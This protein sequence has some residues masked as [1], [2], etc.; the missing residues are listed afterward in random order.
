MAETFAT[1]MTVYAT[2]I[3]N[4]PDVIERI[5]GPDGDEWRKQFYPTIET[6]EN[7]MEHLVFNAV[8][9]GVHDIARLDGWA[10]CDSDAV[11]VEIDDTA[12]STW[13]PTS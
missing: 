1:E 8:V 12:F 13:K 10:D 4:D 6:A 3:V 2:V 7:V 11:K 5:T 9:N